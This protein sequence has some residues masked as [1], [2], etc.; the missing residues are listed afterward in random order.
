[1]GTSVENQQPSMIIA[2]YPEEE[3]VEAG[4]EETGG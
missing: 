2:G 1:M 3:D 4:D